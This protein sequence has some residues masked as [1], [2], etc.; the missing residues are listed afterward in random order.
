MTDGDALI[1]CEGRFGATDGKTA[2]GLVRFTRRYRVRGVIDSHLAGRD[3]GEALDGRPRGVPIVSSLEEGLLLPGPPVTHLVIGV[4]TVGG[5]LP[6][7]LRPT[8][9]AALA[10]GIHVDSG[11][12]EFL[13][14]DPELMRAAAGSGAV[15]RDVRRPAPRSELHFYTGKISEV[16]CPKI[17][18]LGTDCATGK[19][20]TAWLLVSALERAGL[21]A[22]MVGTGQTAWMQG[23]RYGTLLDSIV[24][25]F[26]TGEI[27]HAVW[28]AWKGARPQA[29]V[30]EGQGTLIHPAYPG[31][32]EILGAASP[33]AVVLQHAPGRKHLEGFPGV[34][35]AP[36]AL[37]IEVIRLISGCPT[38][39]ITMSRE[40]MEPSRYGAAA[41]SLARETDR[42]VFDP[43]ADEGAALAALVIERFGL[44][45]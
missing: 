7:E 27:E 38:I 43:L 21:R 28:R 30:I 1:L 33:E 8:I 26:V 19:R 9:A 37:H 16:E 34:P 40:G 31:G 11:L 39:A 14:E 44:R 17:A 10:R 5:R 18:V 24:N 6:A 42:A 35:V 45:P 36:P 20:T 29:I 12:H 3:A 2:H 4:A 41:E 22:E 25:D 15:I 13:G 32:F 23:V